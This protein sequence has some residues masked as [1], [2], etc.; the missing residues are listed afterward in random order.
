MQSGEKGY[1]KKFNNI[2]NKVLH[3]PTYQLFY[4]HNSYTKKKTV[5]Q[6]ITPEEE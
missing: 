4:L 6:I 2:N 3:L 1:N 5:Q